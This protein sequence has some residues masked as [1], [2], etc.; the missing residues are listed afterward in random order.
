M[1]AYKKQLFDNIFKDSAFLAF[2]RMSDAVTRQDGGERIAMPLMYETNSTVETHSGYSIIDQDG[3][4]W[5]A[6]AA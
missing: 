5:M 3:S 2:L 1:A 4:P 6:K